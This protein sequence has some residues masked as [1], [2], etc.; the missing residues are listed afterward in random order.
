MRLGRTF[1]VISCCFA[2]SSMRSSVSVS[3][4]PALKHRLVELFKSNSMIMSKKQV[5]TSLHPFIIIAR[6]SKDI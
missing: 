6:R 3:V 5:H 2:L 4:V 1:V